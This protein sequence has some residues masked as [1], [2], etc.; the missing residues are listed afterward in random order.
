MNGPIRRVGIG[1]VV[2]MLALVGQ[3]TYVQLARSDTLNA[4]PAN[5][6]VSRHDFVHARGE[7]ITADGM[8]V[9][10]SKRVS[11]ELKYLRVYPQQGLYAQVTGFQS[12]LYGSSGVERYYNSTLLGHHVATV[13]SILH[14]DATQNVRLTIDSRA[15]GAAANALAGRRGS[16]VVLDAKTGGVVALYSNPT[17]DPNSLATH[18]TADAR[19]AFTL[20]T[21]NATNP[22]LARAYRELYPPGSTFKIVT[23]ATALDAGIVTALQPFFPVLREIALPQTNNRQLTNFGRELCGGNLTDSFRHSCNTTFAKIGFELGDTLTSGA[24]RFGFGTDAPPLDLSPGLVASKGP[25]PNNGTFA[26]N[27]PAFMLDAI[28]Q[29]D[30]AATPLEM[31]LAAEAVATGGRILV[32]H[33]MQQ[34]ENSDSRHTVAKRA[35]TVTWRTVMPPT[36]AATLTDMMIGVVQHGT[37]TAAQIAGIP[38]AGKTGTAENVVGEKPHA[39]FVGFAPANDPQYVIAVLVEHGGN[40]NSEVTGGAI[41]APIARDIFTTLLRPGA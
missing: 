14:S 33:V 16:V 22:M 11:D 17:F 39:W 13:D 20:S 25:D 26:H 19:R 31:A 34:I 9:A 8:V 3:L 35:D 4:D 30:I 23:A 18:T 36:T 29:Q 7:I 27:Q 6:R 40:A 28:G 24:R 12:L 1:L 10:Y 2:L 32:P 5:F 15:Q 21:L 41:A 38:V 37:G